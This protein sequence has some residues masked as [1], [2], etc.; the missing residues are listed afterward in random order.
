MAWSLRACRRTVARAPVL[1]GLRDA[2]GTA[3]DVAKLIRKRMAARGVD[4]ASLPADASWIRVLSCA[5]FE[6]AAQGAGPALPGT[7]APLDVATQ[8]GAAEQTRPLAKTIG[9]PGDAA[10]CEPELSARPSAMIWEP[11]PLSANFA[12]DGRQ[13]LA[14]LRASRAKQAAS[15]A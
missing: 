4:H 2:F 15:A 13:K 7:E 14:E 8:Q 3:A 1:Y 5:E 9:E 12:A 10:R 11:S 6:A